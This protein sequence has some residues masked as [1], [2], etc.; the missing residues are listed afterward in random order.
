MKL[1]LTYTVLRLNTIMTKILFRLF[2]Q[3]KTKTS[4]K[5]MLSLS[6]VIDVFTPIEA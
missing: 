3:A 1:I 2:E 5:R 4:Y 6:A